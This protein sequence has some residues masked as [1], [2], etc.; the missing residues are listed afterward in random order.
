LKSFQF[1]HPNVVKIH[2]WQ[3][4]EITPEN[5]SYKCFALCMEMDYYRDGDLSS[6]MSNYNLSY[7]DILNIMIQLTEGLVYLHSKNVGHFD[8]KLSNIFMNKG[9][10]ALGMFICY[11]F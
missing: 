6:V 1:D 5:K 7:K 11:F 9:I 10:V 4:V 3:I 2:D 8:I